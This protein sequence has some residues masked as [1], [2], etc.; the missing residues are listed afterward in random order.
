MRTIPSQRHLFDIPDDIAYFNCAYNSPQL[1]EARA[2]LN[3]VA[4]AKSQPWER[5]AP[6][7]FEDA[8]TIRQL[9]SDIFGGD[10]DGWAIVP[11]V[12]YGISTA[13]RAIEP[14]I[15]PGDHILII[16]EEFPSNVLPWQRIAGETGAIL[17][18]IPYPEN[19]NLAQK[20]I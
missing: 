7:F 18:T 9:S 13:A 16:A 4:A 12:S 3:A 1:N 10:A 17:I 14:H 6:G 5:T 20:I 2:R 19:G 8:E 11:A 15:K